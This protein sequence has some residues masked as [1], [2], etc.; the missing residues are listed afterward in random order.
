MKIILFL[1]VT[2][3]IIFG[4]YLLKHVRMSQIGADSIMECRIGLNSAR[5]N[6]D[7]LGATEKYIR[8]NEEEF[9]RIKNSRFI[10]FLFK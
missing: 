7:D 2:T 4:I 1:L 3:N 9:M 6:I 5:Y 8:H 10:D